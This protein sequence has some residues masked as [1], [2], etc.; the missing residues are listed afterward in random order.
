[1]LAQAVAKAARSASVAPGILAVAAPLTSDLPESASTLAL[2]VAAGDPD[3]PLR[4]AAGAAESAWASRQQAWA[5]ALSAGAARGCR[6]TEPPSD[7]DVPAILLGA[8]LSHRLSQSLGDDHA[9]AWDLAGSTGVI[10]AAL[11]AGLLL[12]LDEG[13]LANALSIS[14]STTL[15]HRAQSS[16]PMAAFQIGQAAAN[17]VL[18]AVLA[19][20]GVT[21]SP[22]AIEGPRGL[23]RAYLGEEPA[24]LLA[25]F[26][27][28]WDVLTTIEEPS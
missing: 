25:D 7:R 17:G 15:G 14:A 28:R 3:G 1:L 19:R 10:G 16:S 9:Q 5:W 13:Q 8:E 20:R 23:L 6:S 21:G 22:S 24:A 2:L 27:D 4:A 11:T 18:A 26:G 12:E